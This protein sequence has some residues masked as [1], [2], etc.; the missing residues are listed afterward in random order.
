M[1]TRSEAQERDLKKKL[2]I[3]FSI[4]LAL[5]VVLVCIVDIILY[6]RRLAAKPAQPQVVQPASPEPKSIPTIKPALQYLPVV[7]NSNAPELVIVA[8]AAPAPAI[9]RFISINVNDIGTFENVA[10]PSQ[11][12][13]AKCIDPNRP[14]PNAG[15]LYYLDDKGMLKLEDGSKT[16]QR[17]KLTTG[18]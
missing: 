14:P 2:V 10:D 8:T 15:E 5:L 11:R 13:T 9:W 6:R 7:L 1:E 17:F 12:L 3:L 16:Y 18:Q 4:M